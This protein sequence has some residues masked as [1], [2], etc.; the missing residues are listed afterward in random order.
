V[1]LGKDEERRGDIGNPPRTLQRCQGRSESWCRCPGLGDAMRRP[2]IRSQ[3]ISIHCDGFIFLNF[4]KSLC[5][6][7]LGD[8]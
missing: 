7:G 1:S 4:G 6:A 3:E 5:M 8:F 2:G